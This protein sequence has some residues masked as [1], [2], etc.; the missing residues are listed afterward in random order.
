MGEHTINENDDEENRYHVHSQLLI[1][2]I[3]FMDERIALETDISA[4]D[5]LVDTVDDDEQYTLVTYCTGDSDDFSFEDRANKG[6]SVT[7]RGR[8]RP[9]TMMEIED[10][11]FKNGDKSVSKRTSLASNHRRPSSIGNQSEF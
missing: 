9:V 3:E 1:D 7:R 8:K 4:G 10:D 6:N 11:G 2:N 5:E